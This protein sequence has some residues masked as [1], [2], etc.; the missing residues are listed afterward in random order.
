MTLAR[1]LWIF[2]ALTVGIMVA[3][4]LGP[5]GFGYLNYVVAYVGMFSMIANLGLDVIV[6]KQLI[7]SPE[8]EGRTLGNYF[9]FKLLS[10][11]AMLAALGL[12]FIFL[13][14]KKV[15]PYCLIVATGYCLYPFS[16]VLCPFFA[17]V[18]N[19]YNAWA[20][21][22]CCLIYNTIRLF[23]V[24]NCTSLMP[25]FVAE[26]VM[27]GLSY[28][29]MFL[30]YWKYCYSPLKWSFRWKEVLALL[31]LAL[32]MSLTVIFGLVYSRT[33][34]LMLEHYLG[35]EAVGLYTIAAHF[36][37]NWTLFIQLFAL[38]FSAAVF[39]AYGVSTMEYSKQLHRYYFLLFWISFPPILLMLMLWRPL[40]L[41]LYG[42][43]F[44]ASAAILYWHILTLPSN[45]LLM[46]I[47]SHAVCEKHFGII[48]AV[49]CLGTLLNV[50]LNMLLIPRLGPSGAAISS[51]SAMPLGILLAL[52]CNHAGRGILCVMLRSIFTL[53]SF[54]LG[55]SSQFSQKEV[56]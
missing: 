29:I 54:R 42:K 19:H 14:D 15:I 35:N 25:Y 28:G 10:L 16:V 6:E 18:K 22:I 37:E 3:R 30:F 44:I 45:G 1:L 17:K 49:F 2:T 43:A 53:P 36:T 21:I 5:E 39:S 23:A 9:V 38:V 56:L 48:G 33:D 34:M 51:A 7:A 46:A 8:N 32:P 27:A 4:R 26:A 13:E 50:P 41:F 24:L 40:C 47:H 55:K 31:P 12:S 52:L 11:M 20:Q